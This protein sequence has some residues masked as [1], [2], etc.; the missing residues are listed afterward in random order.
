MNGNTKSAILVVTYVWRHTAH[1]WALAT[2][3]M[4]KKL[5]DYFVGHFKTLLLAGLVVVSLVA[6]GLYFVQS[7]GSIR[8]YKVQFDSVAQLTTGDVVI[9]KGLEVGEVQ[10]L[11]FN[12]EKKVLVTIR[13][14]RDIKLTRGSTFTIY[15]DF[16][17]ST[18]IEIDFVDSN[19]LM[20]TNEIQTGLAQPS[21]MPGFR[22]L[23]AEERD[24]LLKHD[25][26]YR[27]TDTV[28]SALM[29]SRDSTK[30]K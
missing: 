20:D 12:D 19:V 26:V 10:D 22:R 14:G 29:E 4:T 27:L 13:V 30:V 23:T 11:R 7:K 25:P 15:T 2:I 3:P 6:Y 8:I 9:L 17:G 1:T 5:T 28:K 18:H 21:D 16:L 24:S